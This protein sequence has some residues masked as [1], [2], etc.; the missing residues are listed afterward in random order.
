MGGMIKDATEVQTGKIEEIQKN[1][2]SVSVEV[3]S[4]SSRQ[5]A[6]E[7]RMDAYESGQ[8]QRAVFIP[9]GRRKTICVGGFKYDASDKLVAQIKTELDRENILYERVV[10]TGS[11]GERVKVHFHSSDQMWVC[12][13]KMKGRKFSGGSLRQAGRTALW[14]NIDKVGWEI[15]VSKQQVKAV[16][17]L[18]PVLAAIFPNSPQHNWDAAFDIKNDRGEAIFLP[19]SLPGNAH[20]GGPI[21][22]YDCGRT[23][24]KMKIPP[25]A[26]AL[27]QDLSI[28]LKLQTH[29]SEIH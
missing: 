21:K 20:Q 18:K 23:T 9:M 7:A 10:G 1:V 15:G 5:Q 3:R 11:Y 26:N 28:D 17:E 8:Q 14:H 27:L 19:M 4:L 25:T 29:L 22:V 2:T 6:L 13:K 12:L 24:H 16:A